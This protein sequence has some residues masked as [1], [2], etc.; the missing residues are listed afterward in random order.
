MG[1]ELGN[2]DNDHVEGG[3]SGKSDPKMRECSSISLYEHA[4]TVSNNTCC[5]L[6]QPSPS[7]V[8]D[9]SLQEGVASPSE[10]FTSK[11]NYP[12]S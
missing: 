8:F 9:F 5:K 11:G 7:S 10:V 3:E 4:A 1:L 6:A 2:S 12:C